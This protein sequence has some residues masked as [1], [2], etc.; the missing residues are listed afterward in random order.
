RDF[1]ETACAQDCRFQRELGGKPAAHLRVG[2]RLTRFVIE[3]GVASVGAP[4]DAIRPRSED[5]F[6]FAKWDRMFPRHFSKNFARAVAPL[7]L[8][9]FEPAGDTQ[10][11]CPP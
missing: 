10:K 1:R 5:K 7:A 9:A 6:C 8:P 11:A 3:E 2:R 4:L